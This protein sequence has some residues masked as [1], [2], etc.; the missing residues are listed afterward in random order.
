MN[1]VLPQ[2]SVPEP[3][4]SKNPSPSSRPVFPLFWLPPEPP[5]ARLFL[6]PAPTQAD[7]AALRGWGALSG[8]QRKVWCCSLMRELGVCGRRPA[9]G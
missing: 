7:E 1:D 4:T 9:V 3:R 5:P 8:L 2:I 6:S